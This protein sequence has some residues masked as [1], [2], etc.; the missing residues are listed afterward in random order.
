[1]ALGAGWPA[2]PPTGTPDTIRAFRVS[3]Q[4]AKER[5]MGRAASCPKALASL[6]S[7]VNLIHAG[8]KLEVLKAFWI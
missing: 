4:A 6:A 8:F 2:V 3:S 1:M 7:K 5:G